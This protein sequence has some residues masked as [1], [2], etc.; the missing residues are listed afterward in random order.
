MNIAL[1]A[2]DSRK[3]LMVQFCIAYCGILSKHQI[4]A[5]GTTGQIV[6]DA[7]GLNIIC[8][9]AAQGG[10]QQITSRIAY[11]EID[12]VLYF[13]DPESR[14]FFKS[15]SS[16][17]LRYCDIH[18]IPFATNVATAEMLILGLQRGDLDWRDIVN[19]KKK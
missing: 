9:S 17:V 13:R 1:I 12:L 2:D 18:N 3:E 5:T 15:E 16:D 6:H 10:D 14:D 7:T 19:P 8:F 4:C 11:N